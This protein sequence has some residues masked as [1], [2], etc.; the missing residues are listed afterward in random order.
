MSTESS[1]KEITESV[2]QSINESEILSSTQL[3]DIANTIIATCFVYA[4]VK[5]IVDGK[6]QSV[7]NWLWLL[8]YTGLAGSMAGTIDYTSVTQG[9]SIS[10]LFCSS[11]SSFSNKSLLISSFNAYK[12]AAD[13]AAKIFENSKYSKISAEEFQIRSQKLVLS[14]K[15]AL[16]TC[17]TNQRTSK[18]SGIDTT[19]ESFSS[20][21]CRELVKV[22]LE[23][24]SIASLRKIADARYKQPPGFSLNP[25]NQEFLRKISD[26]Y[27]TYSG[28]TTFVLMP[29]L[30]FLSS[31][32]SNL[33]FLLILIITLTSFIF[34][35]PLSGFLIIDSTRPKFW[36]AYRS[37]LSLGLFGFI[38]SFFNLI[39]NMLLDSAL[40]HSAQS[41]EALLSIFY[42]SITLIIK[43]SLIIRA[44]KFAKDLMN[45]SLD[46]ITEVTSTVLNGAAM[47]AVGTIASK[48][49][50]G[51][52]L[53]RDKATKVTGNAIKSGFNSMSNSANNQPPRTPTPPP[54]PQ[55]ATVQ[56]TYEFEPSRPKR[57][58]SNVKQVRLTPESKAR[59]LASND[60]P[61]SSTDKKDEEKLNESADIKKKKAA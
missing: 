48:V 14:N 60:A 29:A 51:A 13:K 27:F 18:I 39:S 21:Q 54:L 8:V 59:A 55:E 28:F 26:K 2:I 35:T 49:G 36:A 57:T 23:S 56:R 53:V 32:I 5:I 20:E 61:D 46:S 40:I 50:T 24:Q 30:F 17:L 16:D 25:L 3:L 22:S 12:C 6:A 33:M 45:V 15:I 52:T 38:F 43:V 31:L 4:A 42:I 34:L 1:F 10:S 19:I 9:R 58:N 7:A 44:P 47:L 11:A 41:S 37:F